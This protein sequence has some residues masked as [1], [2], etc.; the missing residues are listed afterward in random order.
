M[1]KQ[2][3]LNDADRS[4]ITSLLGKGRTTIEI[5]RIMGRD[6]RTIKAFVFSGNIERKTPER[7]HWKK[8]NCER[9]P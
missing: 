6:Y 4:R 3:G 2:A 5:S 8:K 7:S 1:G 9:S